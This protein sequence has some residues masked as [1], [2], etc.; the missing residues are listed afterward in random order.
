M[1]IGL[2]YSSDN[3][4]FMFIFNSNK[5]KF[6]FM[7]SEDSVLLGEKKKHSKSIF[8]SDKSVM[9]NTFYSIL[10]VNQSISLYTWAA[11]L[12][13]FYRTN[14][15]EEVWLR[16]LVFLNQQLWILGACHDVFFLCIFS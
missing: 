16:K 4:T 11:I 9:E 3:D 7:F 13:Q 12:C 15:N 8:L 2:Y 5:P 6:D 14:N 10:F 1:I